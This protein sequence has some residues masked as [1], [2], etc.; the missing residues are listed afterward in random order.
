MTPPMSNSD[1]ITQAAELAEAKAAAKAADK[2]AKAAA[3]AAAKA[4]KPPAAPRVRKPRVPK[5]PPRMKIR[6]GV[7][8][9]GGLPVSTFDYPERGA[10]DA[11]AAKAGKGYVVT[12]VRVVMEDAPPAT[13]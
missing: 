10:A 8:P 9:A 2:V 1:R 11:A 4:A 5:A 3:R 12:A 6:W 13:V 7:G